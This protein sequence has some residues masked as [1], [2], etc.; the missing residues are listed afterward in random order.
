MLSYAAL[1]RRTTWTRERNEPAR[2]LKRRSR[3]AK[4]HGKTFEGLLLKLSMTLALA[5]VSIGLASAHH[6]IAEFDYTKN[7]SIEG[8]VK[9]V[10]WTNPHTR[11]MGNR[12][13]ISEPQY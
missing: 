13:R 10:Q 6:S 2:E 1:C 8:I 5:C 9:E 11:P 7:V 3:G 4:V 12:D